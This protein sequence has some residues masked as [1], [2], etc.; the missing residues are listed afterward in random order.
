MLCK[1]LISDHPP[2]PWE[3][4]TV[5]IP[6]EENS[7][8]NAAAVAVTQGLNLLYLYVYRYILKKCNKYI[9]KYSNYVNIVI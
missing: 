3:A 2:F 7:Q 8:N 1:L 5:H 6:Y 4:E 9:C